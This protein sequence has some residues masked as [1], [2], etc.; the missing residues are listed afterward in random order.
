M[1][2]TVDRPYKILIVD[3]VP[4][5]IQIVAG[6]LQDEGCQLA[7]AQNGKAALEQI[8]AVAFDLILLDI[9]MPEM[10]GFA[11]CREFKRDPVNRD[12]PVIFLTAKT[13]IGSTVNGLELGAV[14]YVTKPFD[15]KEL[16]ARVKTHLELKRSREELVAINRTKD[17]LFS[18]I[19]H[20]LKNPLGAF[21]NTTEL[22][23]QRFDRM[24]DEDKRKFIGM[25]HESSEHLYGL[26]ENLLHWARSQ[27]GDLACLPEEMCP[28]EVVRAAVDVLSMSAERKGVK[29]CCDPQID[30]P[31]FADRRMFE[32]VVRNVVANAIKFTPEGGRVTIVIAEHNCDIELRVSDSGVGTTP[33]Q[34]SLVFGEGRSLS[35]EGTSRETGTGLGLIISR[36]FVDRLGGTI[37]AESIPGKG[38]TVSVSLPQAKSL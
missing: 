25:M 1:S 4:K 31:L 38:T 23:A 10:D 30:K 26:L 36:E 9:M 15:A 18:V 5:N 14:D 37:R 21:K 6:I 3:D 8:A 29:L 2:D 24:E 34:L 17:K 16:L 32:T 7:F 27:T 20:D 11:F 22:M 28:A 35:S 19:A 13:D 12:I 33:D